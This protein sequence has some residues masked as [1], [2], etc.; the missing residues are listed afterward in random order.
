MF[1]LRDIFQRTSVYLINCLNYILIGAQ[2]NM[3]TSDHHGF[4]SLMKITLK[5]STFPAGTLVTCQA[6]AGSTSPLAVTAGK[7][8]VGVCV[9][10]ALFFLICRFSSMADLLEDSKEEAALLIVW[11][12][13][14]AVF[15][16]CSPLKMADVFIPLL[17]CPSVSEA[18]RKFAI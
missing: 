11:R 12:H 14:P 8:L 18:R 15:C 7:G 3:L 16:K 4:A 9:V 13:A 6:Y 5:M 1:I 10:A 2:T 17:W